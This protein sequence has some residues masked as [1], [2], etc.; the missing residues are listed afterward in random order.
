[1]LL[2]SNCVKHHDRPHGR[3]HIA[4]RDTHQGVQLTVSDDGPGVEARFLE[5]IFDPLTTLESRDLVEGSGMG[6]TIVRRIAQLN[7]GHVKAISTD[8]KRGT[9][10]VIR[11]P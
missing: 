3:I 11:F 6:L 7:G 5:K 4:C 8:G 9:C 10:I 1:M 2:L